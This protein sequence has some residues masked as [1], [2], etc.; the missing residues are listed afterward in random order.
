MPHRGDLLNNCGAVPQW[1]VAPIIVEAYGRSETF[2]T[3]GGKAEAVAAHSLG[4]MLPPLGLPGTNIY[5]CGATL[6]TNFSLL[7]TTLYE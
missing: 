2:L 4:A 7:R 3:S 6:M 5:F 1:G